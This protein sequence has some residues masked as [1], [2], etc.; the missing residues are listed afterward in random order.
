MLLLP[1]NRSTASAKRT[2]KERASVR[3]GRALKVTRPGIPSLGE[4]PSESRESFKSPR[5]LCPQESN[6]RLIAPRR[7]V[8]GIPVLSP[9]SWCDLICCV[10]LAKTRELVWR[11]GREDFSRLPKEST[12][13][14]RQA[15]L[16]FV[17]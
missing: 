17:F 6:L 15:L 13:N 3:H 1:D 5:N 14:Q 10:H 8:P 9:Y 2:A 12:S 4:A 7:S 11:L 16:A